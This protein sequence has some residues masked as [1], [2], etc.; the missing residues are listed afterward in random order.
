M[1]L[2]YLSREF[3]IKTLLCIFA[4]FIIGIGVGIMRFVD[5]GIDPFMCLVNGLN[6]TIS[7]YI[8]INFG[9]TFIIFN[10][11]VLILIFIFGRSY[12]GLGTVLVM[13]FGGYF[14]DFGL[15]LCR[16][17]LTAEMIYF[18][19]RIGIMIFGIIFIA[20][21]SGIYFNTNI[22]VSA[23]DASGLIITDKINN[24]NLYRFVRIATDIICVLGGFFMGNR[25]GIGTIIMAFFTGPLFS[26]FR[27]RFLVWGKKQK[28]ITWQ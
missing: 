19:F 10:F 11:L 15:F 7:K 16:L 5:L 18:I 14:S 21:G 27:S 2:R 12:I 23:Y 4:I 20:I 22:G 8:N 13:L 26:F 3:L 28:I 17:F 6:L 24:Q 25:P 9:T 1:Y